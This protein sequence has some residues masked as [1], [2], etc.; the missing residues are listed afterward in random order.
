MAQEL[1]TLA[2]LPDSGCD[3]DLFGGGAD[4]ALGLDDPGPASAGWSVLTTTMLA[5]PPPAT[6]EAALALILEHGVSASTQRLVQLVPELVAQLF[7]PTVGYPQRL[8]E[9]CG[10]LHLGEADTAAVLRDRERYL[11]KVRKRATRERWEQVADLVC[12]QVQE[13]DAGGAAA[14]DA[15]V[16]FYRLDPTL[17]CKEVWVR[18]RR[19]LPRGGGGLAQRFFAALGDQAP[20]QKK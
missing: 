11:D 5:A 6:D 7:Q 15:L 9:V 1:Q 16:A 13:A 17:F 3:A 14:L 19:R 2:E 10:A 20:K 4:G 12:L 8:R 18:V